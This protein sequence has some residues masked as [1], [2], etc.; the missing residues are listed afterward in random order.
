MIWQNDKS[1]NGPLCSSRLAPGRNRPFYLVRFPPFFQ[2]IRNVLKRIFLLLFQ[3]DASL[4]TCIRS[5]FQ[6]SCS[7][8]YHN[9]VWNGKANCASQ[10]GLLA[11]SNISSNKLKNVHLGRDLL[12][13]KSKDFRFRGKWKSSLYK[14]I[15]HRRITKYLLT[16]IT[17]TNQRFQ[18][19]ALRKVVP[20]KSMWN[21]VP[22]LHTLGNSNWNFCPN[23]WNHSVTLTTFSR[24]QMQKFSSW[25]RRIVCTYLF[26]TTLLSD[27]GSPEAFDSTFLK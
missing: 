20:S 27:L 4:S 24:H 15:F 17:R 3:N 21:T 22:L 5:I 26:M 12:A 1:R 25:K 14:V 19:S 8:E 7:L 11:A 16:Q 9:E 23:G 18:I 13:P 2:T 10:I 6:R